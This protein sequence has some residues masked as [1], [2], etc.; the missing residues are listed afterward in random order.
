[1]GTLGVYTISCKGAD[2]DLN[3]KPEVPAAIYFNVSCTSDVSVPWPS[4]P[5]FYLS[6]RLEALKE[7]LPEVADQITDAKLQGCYFKE[8][9]NN[10]RLE[11][12]GKCVHAWGRH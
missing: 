9:A 11:Y 5:R 6:H 4:C 8:R 1:M 10:V 3:P 7:R 2:P 12:V